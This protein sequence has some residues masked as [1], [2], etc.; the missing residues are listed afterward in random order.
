MILNSII[1]FITG[2]FTF[3]V[4]LFPD[5]DPDVAELIAG[6]VHGFAVTIQGFNW[7][8]PVQEFVTMIL[9][10]FGLVT[11]LLIVN[12]VRWIGSIVSGRLFH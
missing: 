10:L 7:I 12:L 11:T 6:S 5:A 1:V 3:I 9:I 2:I 4:N 8:F